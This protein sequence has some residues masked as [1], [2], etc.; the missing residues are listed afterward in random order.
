MASVR[1][2]GRVSVCDVR[3]RRRDE[4]ARPMKAIVVNCSTGHNG[5]VRRL[6]VWLQRR[7]ADVR[8]LERQ[9]RRRPRGLPGDMDLAWADE[10]YLS[11]VLNLGANLF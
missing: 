6:A 5:A 9:G 1:G 3:S 8:V 2:E 10:V 7:G 4:R 11:V